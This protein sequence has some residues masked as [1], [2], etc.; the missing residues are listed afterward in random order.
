MFSFGFLKLSK[1]NIDIQISNDDSIS[2][3]FMFSIKNI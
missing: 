1:K 3:D 2:T